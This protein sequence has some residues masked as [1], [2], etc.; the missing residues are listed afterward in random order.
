MLPRRGDPE[1]EVGRAVSAFLGGHT[2]RLDII[3]MRICASPA[4][5]SGTSLA[6]PR[7]KQ[8]AKISRADWAPPIA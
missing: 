6:N 4:T 3:H 5:S 2:I 7:G 1:R 8:E